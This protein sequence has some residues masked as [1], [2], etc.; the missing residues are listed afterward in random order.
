M[1]MYLSCL[2]LI[3]SKQSTICNYDLSIYYLYVLLFNYIIFFLCV[4]IFS[5]SGRNR[6]LIGYGLKI[7][8]H[9]EVWAKEF[10]VVEIQNWIIVQGKRTLRTNQWRRSKPNP[11][12]ALGLLVYERK[13]RW[14][15]NL[16]I[17]SLSNNQ[18][19]SIKKEMIAKGVWKTFQKRHV[20]KGLVNKIFFTQKFFMSWMEWID[21]MEYYLNKLGAMVDNL[22]VW[23]SYK[24]QKIKRDEI[25]I[26]Y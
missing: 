5:P 10:H 15:L 18:F 3:T 11:S 6:S 23:E 2:N 9:K 14:A 7:W 25:N 22:G 21:T 19:M 8:S 20:D 4:L 13:D 16:L 26:L 17:Q 1:C 24:R 12:N